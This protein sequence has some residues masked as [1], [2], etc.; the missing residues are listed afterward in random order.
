MPVLILTVILLGACVV[1][2]P[3]CPGGFMAPIV[4]DSGTPENGCG[5]ASLPSDVCPPG[6]QAHP[7]MGCDLIPRG[8]AGA[9]VACFYLNAACPQ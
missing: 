2:P 7:L 9:L 3:E 8:D 4:V 6:S 1:G 5:S